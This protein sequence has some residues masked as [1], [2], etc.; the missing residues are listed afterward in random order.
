[1][2]SRGAIAVALGLL[3]AA[4]VCAFCYFNDL[5]MRQTFLVGNYMPISV[6][7]GLLVFILVVN[8]LLF[9]IRKRLALTGR[10]LA[11]IV[12]L[13]LAACYV[14]GR[15][16][17][18]YFMT[19]MMMP[20]HYERT[21]PSWKEHKIVQMPPKRMLA[22]VP[23]QYRT[24]DV[25]D[26][27]GFY[28]QLIDE[29]ARATA[30]PSTLVWDLLPEEVRQTA[31][32]AKGAAEADIARYAAITD[33]L[34]AALADRWFYRPEDFED[35]DLP[36]Q[37]ED[38]A[39][40][41]NESLPGGL[42]GTV[43]ASLLARLGRLDRELLSPPIALWVAERADA[44]T[45]LSAHEALRLNRAALESAYPKAV[46]T[47]QRGVFRLTP[48]EIV[49][50]PA[51]CTLLRDQAD[52]RGRNPG[53][54]LWALLGESTREAVDATLVIAR[55]T[56]RRSATV[57][58]AL[59]RILSRPGLHRRKALE[60][61]VLPKDGQD[62]LARAQGAPDAEREPLDQEDVERLN[63][64]LLDA[65][66]PDGLRSLGASEDYVLSG[67]LQGLAVG[68]ERMPWSKIPWYAWERPLRFWV[69]FLLSLLLGMIGLAVVVHRQWSD[70]EHLPYPIVTFANAL[71]PRE[72]RPRGGVFRSKLF[73]GGMA[74]IFFI[75][76]NN[77]M[78]AWWPQ[79]MVPVQRTFDFTTLAPVLPRFRN[80]WALLNPT[81]YFTAIGF[82]YFLATDVSLALGIGPFVYEIVAGAFLAYGV[83]FHG[84]GFLSLQIFTFLYAGAYLGMFLVLLYTGRH[85]YG[86]VLR[87]S[88]FLPARDEPERASVWGARVFLLGAA[89]FTVQLALLGVT[90][91]LAVVYTLGTV[92]IFTVISRVV[93]ETG[94]FFIHAFN[95][96]CVLLWGFLGARVI[97]PQSLL[98][99]FMV[100]SLLLIDPRESVMPF[101]VQG[102][103]LVD[104]N[105]ARVGRTAV[106]GGVALV[107]GFVVAI[108]A[109]LYWQYSLGVQVAG[110][111]WTRGV[112]RM[113][114]DAT[115]RAMEK[116][117][118]QG[119]LEQAGK[120]AGGDWV[121]GLSPNGPCVI[122]F[123][124]A[125]VLVLL[126]AA[127]R[128]RFARWPIHPI[129]FLALGGFQSR[130]L[131][132]SFLLGCL[133]KVVVTK[134]GGA[135]VYQKLKPLMIGVIAGDMLGGLM[136]MAVGAVYW[137]STGDPPRRFVVLP[138]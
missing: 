62:L 43:E 52:R 9:W 51:F 3:G 42:Q 91:Y 107:L 96:P 24:A 132:V 73:W 72:G 55:H 118:A 8:P 108:P 38:L 130:T 57:V 21:S 98:L 99:M 126:F 18:H 22:G 100:T 37:A 48:R 64:H 29:G 82:A 93:A 61:L 39:R 58:A 90:W 32:E 60:G 128:L 103:K 83:T 104:L 123:F 20:H 1:M 122:A 34:N 97:G 50:W 45:P 129:M 44:R 127:G 15:G 131:A 13:T 94:V 109:T 2:R 31:R 117:K 41:K 105:K 35:I 86:N 135:A 77:Y 26:P 30:S 28:S 87:R 12:A 4:A 7:G 111:G 124:A 23:P 81:V 65:A 113:A 78:H 56:E 133:I 17:A 36:T 112:P 116:L 138:L 121:R 136:P 25:K 79:T 14:P 102:F 5:V 125:L 115:V 70:H 95:F 69:P 106:W 11:V 6:Y 84:G 68:K 85:Y 40:R 88:L 66:F 92:M 16:L 114:F 137:Y 76:M 110:D 101:M 47:D 63:R 119:V 53:K 134:F 71:L 75:H 120:L 80:Y 10:Q 67:F 54:R 89:A 27:L 74:V 46:S 49:D 33:A 59:N 19:F